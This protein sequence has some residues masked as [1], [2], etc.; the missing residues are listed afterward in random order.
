MLK[1]GVLR[2]DVDGDTGG[3]EEGG[4]GTNLVLLP[5]HEDGETL[6]QGDVIS[7]S[8][9]VFSVVDPMKEKY[10]FLYD[11]KAAY[12]ELYPSEGTQA[13]C[14]IEDYFEGLSPEDRLALNWEEHAQKIHDEILHPPLVPGTFKK[15]GFEAY[16]D[17]FYNYKGTFRT[18]REANDALAKALFV[19]PEEHLFGKSIREK[20]EEEV[21]ETGMEGYCAFFT[22]DTFHKRP[23]ANGK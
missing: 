19:I 12:F 2:T 8:K 16:D 7:T 11:L 23:L 21:I 9:A 10:E 6:V 5:E 17:W 14:A 20:T 22:V 4:K 18:R 13:T 3:N 1:G 15:F